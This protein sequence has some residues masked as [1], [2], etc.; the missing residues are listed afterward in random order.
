M[1]ELVSIDI[2]CIFME[3]QVWKEEDELY[4]MLY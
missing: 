3:A 2:D 4:L 1:I